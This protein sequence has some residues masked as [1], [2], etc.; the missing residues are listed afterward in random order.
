MMGIENVDILLQRA[1]VIKTRDVAQAMALLEDALSEALKNDYRRGIALAIREKSSCHLQQQHFKQALTG[2]TEAIQFFSSLEDLSGQISCHHEIASIYRMLGDFPSSL[3]HV[4]EKLRLYT[5]I[6]D[7]RGIAG[8]YNEIGDVHLLLSDLPEAIDWYKKAVKIF[9]GLKDRQESIACYYRL[10]HA[11][12]LSDEEDRALYY[13]LR[14]SNALAESSDLDLKTR[15]LAGLAQLYTRQKEYEQALNHFN[16]ALRIAKTGA[17]LP[18]MIRLEKSMGELYLEL[19]QYDKAIEILQQAV[20]KS[21]GLPP[22]PDTVQLHGLLATAYERIGDFGQ[23]LFHH[24]QFHGLDKQ[25]TS[26]AVSLKTKAMHFRFD[27]EELRKQ[28]EIAELSDKLKEQ[29]LANVSHEIR[30]PMNGVIGMAHLLNRTQPTR[31][32]QE[33]IDAIKDSANNLMVIINDILDFSKINAGKIEFT[34]SE[35]S[36]RELVR[37]VLQVLKVKADE[38][39]LQLTVTIDYHAKDLLI[40]DPIRLNQIL[41]NLIGNAVKFTD[42]GRVAIDIRQVREKEGVCRLRFTIS[43]TGIGIPEDRLM[44]IF[45]SFEQA[46][47]NKRRHEGTG[48]GLTIVKQ[49]VELQGGTVGVKSRPGEGSEFAFELPFTIGQETDEVKPVRAITA[50]EPADLSSLRILVVEDNRINQLLVRNMLKQHGIERIDAT[51]NGR[52]AIRLLET[53]SFDLVLMDIQLPD[54][55]GY[56]I[57]RIIRSRLP[58]GKRDI[59]VIALTADASEKVRSAAL[60]AGMD[61][62]LV[63]PYSPEELLTKLSTFASNV[64][65]REERMLQQHLH[66]KR[67]IPGVQLEALEKFT[68]GDQEL[69]VQLIEIFLRQLPDALYRIDSAISRKDW[70][71]V[72]AAAHKIKSSISIFDLKSLRRLIIKIEEGARDL[73]RLDEISSVFSAFKTEAESILSSFEKELERLRRERVG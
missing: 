13:L 11:F 21:S 6:T 48:L 20:E 25:V 66:E 17:S 19:T 3:L 58:V 37:G 29:F 30:T 43:D 72:H 28:K 31:E 18:V 1:Q 68:G 36:L 35:F 32:Q 34:R 42:K 54:M 70:P 26:E 64:S 45:E 40:G 63:K 38:K 51:D 41:M 69:T 73:H 67:K 33:Y 65:D 44:N 47:N 52:E 7:S 55:N 61:D 62:Y 50:A 16:Q 8:C 10:G 53:E 15:T 57:T 56:E 59:P 39:R 46:G 24:K 60:A 27:L 49:L 14:A 9:E 71:E 4:L 23:A 12:I 22:D 5:S 2:Y